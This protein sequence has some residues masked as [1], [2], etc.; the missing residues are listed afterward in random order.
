MKT[1]Q[2][3][4]LWARSIVWPSFILAAL[5]MIT[6]L[7]IA[8]SVVAVNEHDFQDK[9]AFARDPKA[10][11]DK[12]DRVVQEVRADKQLV[13]DLAAVVPAEIKDLESNPDD[14]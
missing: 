11:W 1:R 13:K 2:F 9:I 8:P 7:A 3:L 10:H 12:V 5:A 6:Y 14:K 4:T